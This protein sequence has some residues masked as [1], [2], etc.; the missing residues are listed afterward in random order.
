MNNNILAIFGFTAPVVVSLTMPE[1]KPTFSNL[2]TTVTETVVKFEEGTKFGPLLNTYFGGVGKPEVPNEAVINYSESLKSMWE[3]KLSIPNVS[4]ATRKNA[5]TIIDRYEDNP[6]TIMSIQDIAWIA[7]HDVQSSQASIHWEE[8]CDRMKLNNRQCNNSRI[9]ASKINGTVLV[10]YSMT[11]LMPGKNGERNYDLYNKLATTAGWQYIASI[12]AMGDKYLSFGP[13]QFTSFAI[14]DDGKK[15]DGASVVNRF[16]DKKIAS[17]VVHLDYNDQHVAANYF[18][19]YNIMR[20]NRKF[21]YGVNPDCFSGMNLAVFI[22]TAHHNPKHAIDSSVRYVRT[23]CTGSYL[24]HF[25]NKRVKEYGEK[26]IANYI[27]LNER[28]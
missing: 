7:N 28:I 14:Y 3:K 20:L 21:E 1:A 25:K 16:A 27:A 18:A 22:A 24:I 2:P 9:I 5:K 8:L 13:Y 15:A 26:T 19:I 12:P 23:K 17:S 11:E 4:P 6:S 10:S